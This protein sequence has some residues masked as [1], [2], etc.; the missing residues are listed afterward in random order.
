MIS[1]I[2]HQVKKVKNRGIYLA[3]YLPKKVDMM[4]DD[5]Y[6]IDFKYADE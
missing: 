6:H 1:I 5:H 4:H 2:H 3:R